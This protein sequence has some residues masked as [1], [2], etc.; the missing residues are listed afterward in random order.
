LAT[1]NPA[2][3]GHVDLILFCVKSYDVA[4]AATMARP[5]V[6][7]ETV[8]IPIQNGI[9]HIEVL[10]QILGEDRVLGGVSLISADRAV[11]GVVRH[12]QAGDSIEFGEIG[13]GFSRRC[14]EVEQALAVEGINVSARPNIVERMWWK[15]AAYSGVGVFCLVRGDRGVVWRIPETKA[16]YR[17]A[18]A[19]AVAIAQARGMHLPDSVPDEHVAILDSFPPDWVPSEL[20]AIQVGRPLELEALQGAL[21]AIGREAG[22]PTPINDIVYACLK[23]YVGGAAQSR[24]EPKTDARC[25]PWE[26]RAD[27]GML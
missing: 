19:E 11:P 24:R 17:Q 12:K 25:K 13:G 14:R 1:D 23:P 22:I 7:P 21:C 16:L 27:G 15:L 26:S 5:M 8:V 18:V 3:V 2:E 6:G 4:Q 20:V 9:G 10:S